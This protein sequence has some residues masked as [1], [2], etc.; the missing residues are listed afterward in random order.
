MSA[1]LRYAHLCMHMYLCSVYKCPQIDTWPCRCK[2]SARKI[3]KAHP[4]EYTEPPSKHLWFCM[5]KFIHLCPC[6]CEK[7][8]KAHRGKNVQNTPAQCTPHNPKRWDSKSMHLYVWR[9]RSQNVCT[10]VQHV[11]MHSQR[12]NCAYSQK[13]A[14]QMHTSTSMH[15]HSYN[16]KR[17][18]R[19]N[20]CSSM[21]KKMNAENTPPSTLIN[22]CT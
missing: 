19:C 8:R 15:K 4:S 22:S 21:Q 18:W 9:T 3:Q 12:H 1:K 5:R 2:D 11:C 10:C 16:F 14:P 6:L 7:T 20:V 17:L 13:Y